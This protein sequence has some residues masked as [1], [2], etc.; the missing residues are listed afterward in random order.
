MMNGMTI[1][2]AARRAGV[3]VETIRF[4][5][6]KGLIKQP[7]RSDATGFRLYGE[8]T[9]RRVRFIR[10]AQ[11]IGFS[12][13]EI[14]DLL[15]LH[16][17]PSADCADVRQ[18]AASKLVEVDRKIARLGRIRAALEQMITA[19]P[20]QGALRACSIMDALTDSGDPV[21]L[22]ADGKHREEVP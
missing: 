2:K 7:S 15:S 20:G 14:S 22:T 11:D 12:L 10:R 5:E 19:C 17:D 16:A 1:S 6:R 4:Y 18:R 9:V 21:I 8:D 13:S 3:G